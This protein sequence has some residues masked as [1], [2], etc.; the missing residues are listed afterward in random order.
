MTAVASGSSTVMDGGIATEVIKLTLPNPTAWS[1]TSRLSEVLGCTFEYAEAP[2]SGT[3][4][5]AQAEKYYTLSGRT[6][7]FYLPSTA[8]VDTEIFVTIYGRL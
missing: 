8:G 3:T 7:T 2:S 5:Y 4:T 6:I 1:Y